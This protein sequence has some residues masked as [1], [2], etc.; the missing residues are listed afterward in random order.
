MHCAAP[1]AVVVGCG[2]YRLGARRGFLLFASLACIGVIAV[3]AALNLQFPPLSETKLKDL[4]IEQVLYVALLFLS[5]VAPLGSLIGWFAS[6]ENQRA[7]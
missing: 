4:Q 2:T 1:V 3:T 7:N 6:T 5:A